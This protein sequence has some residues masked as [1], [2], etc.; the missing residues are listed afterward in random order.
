MNGATLDHKFCYDIPADFFK[1]IHI[2]VNTNKNFD[3]NHIYISLM[4]K[5][6]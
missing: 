3:R 4:I 6:L 5:S 1:Y 2:Y